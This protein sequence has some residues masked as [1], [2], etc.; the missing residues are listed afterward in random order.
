M[1]LEPLY[2]WLLSIVLYLL[3]LGE[4]GIYLDPYDAEPKDPK[5]FGSKLYFVNDLTERL[6]GQFKE[7]ALDQIKG[8]FERRGWLAGVY[9][10]GFHKGMSDI[11]F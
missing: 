6:Y 7:T 9:F 11:L 8:A 3:D 10:E 2:W 5:A 1:P 4:I